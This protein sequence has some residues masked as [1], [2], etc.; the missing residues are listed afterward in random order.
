MSE[1]AQSTAVPRE[2]N[3]RRTSS[4]PIAAA[5]AAQRRARGG[6][7][8][9]RLHFHSH[10]QTQTQVTTIWAFHTLPTY[11]PTASALCASHSALVIQVLH[12][13]DPF[14]PV[15]RRV[16]H[17]YARPT[18]GEQ[19]RNRVEPCGR[20]ASRGPVIQINITVITRQLHARVEE[21]L[22]R[23]SPSSSHLQTKRNKLNFIRRDILPTLDG[24]A[25][26]LYCKCNLSWR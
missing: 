12:V 10:L 18:F 13:S 14:G 3:T 1:S 19:N 4:R 22:C 8:Q 5:G 24:L 21:P 7:R 25:P 20:E 6:S 15:R 23:R 2:H 17:T 26:I 16:R 11:F 9:R